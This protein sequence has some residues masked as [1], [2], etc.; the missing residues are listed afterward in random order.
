MVFKGII[1][2]LPKDNNRYLVRIPPLEDNTTAEF[3]LPALLCNQPGEYGNYKVG[4][5]VFIEFENNK[6]DTPVILGKLYTGVPEEGLGYFKIDRLEVTGNL[7]MPDNTKLGG[8][9]AE[10]F[11]NLYQRAE[12]TLEKLDGAIFYKELGEF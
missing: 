1:K 11:F 7:V 8:Y 2:E 3:I 9:S 6:L 12:N 4:D 10:D 5:V